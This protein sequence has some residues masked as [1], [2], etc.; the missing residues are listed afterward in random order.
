MFKEIEVRQLLQTSIEAKAE[1]SRAQK[2][3][4]AVADNTYHILK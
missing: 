3:N 4:N 1:K 2:K